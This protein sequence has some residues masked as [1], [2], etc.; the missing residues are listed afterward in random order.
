MSVASD[1]LNVLSLPLSHFD[2]DRYFIDSCGREWPL[3]TI[4]REVVIDREVFRAWCLKAGYALPRFWFTEED[5]RQSEKLLNVHVKQNPEPSPSSAT[6]ALET[7]R[8]MK[9]EGQEKGLQ[10][11][12]I[13]RGIDCEVVNTFNDKPALT[14]AQVGFLFGSYNEDQHDTARKSGRRL[15][16]KST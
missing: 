12:E 9:K 13:I 4:L 11:K 2:E 14:D 15:R 3:E 6:K 8:K 1:M 5:P 10:D 7:A 16:G